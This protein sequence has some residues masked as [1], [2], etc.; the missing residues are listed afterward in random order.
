MAHNTSQLR[1]TTVSGMFWKFFERISSQLVSLIVSIILARI[2]V[3]DDYGVVS[4]VTIF[5]SFANI[6][7]SGGFSSAL[8]Q[9]KDANIQ[10]YSNILY[11][12]LIFSVIIYT[13]LFVASPYI[14]NFYEM[15][16]LVPV[17]RVMVIT[18]FINSFKSVLCAYLGSK[19]QFR[20]FFLVTIGGIIISAIVGIYMALKGYGCWAL[21]AQQMT[22]TIVGTIILLF[23]TRVKFVLRFKP[24]ESVGLFKF[25]WKILVA[26]EISV[27]Y[28]EINPLVIGKRFSAADLA[29]YNKGR[30]F[31]GLL[32][33]SIGGTLSGVLFP[34][35]AKVQDD[36]ETMLKFLRRYIKISS[37]IICPMMVGFLAVAKNF[38]L[39]A[40]TAKW[41]EATIYIQIFCIVYMF[42]IIQVGNLQVIQAMGKSDVILKLEII[43]KSA[44]FVVILLFILF[45]NNPIHLAL[46]CVVNTFIA[47][48]VNTAPNRK[49][50]GY[51]YRYQILDLLPNLLTAFIMVVPVALIGYFNLSPILSLCLQIIVGIGIYLLINLIIKNESLYYIFGMAKK[52]FKSKKVENS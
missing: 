10:D 51:K 26:S 44:Y 40:L 39:V 47:S 33:S 5:F 14:S 18:L 15:P 2:L 30:S 29:F 36:K 37:F 46:A 1:K 42:N 22:N 38:V 45:T 50:I 32:N 35:M 34:V 52:I 3:P 49:L 28:D 7:I 43:K 23:T 12:N 16:I 17:I 20:K 31:P 11:F 9:K 25:G 24:K 41:L 19:L 6:F 8:M 27:L 21:V 13:G 48:I 4:I